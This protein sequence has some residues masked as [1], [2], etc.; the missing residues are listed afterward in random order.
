MFTSL[1]CSSLLAI[2]TLSLSAH[3]AELLIERISYIQYASTAGFEGLDVNF[4][5]MPAAIARR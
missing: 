3:E 4:V 2:N 5:L 1:C